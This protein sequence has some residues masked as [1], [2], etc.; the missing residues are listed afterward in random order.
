MMK[1]S[2]N[3][4][5]IATLSMLIIFM[6]FIVFVNLSVKLD[7]LDEIDIIMPDLTQV[8]DGTYVGSYEVFPLSVSVEVT[9]TSQVI[10]MI[11]ITE[12]SLF[13]D[14]QAEDIISFILQSQTLD[15]AFSEDY[16]QSEKI[17]LLAITNALEVLEFAE[18]DEA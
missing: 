12:S 18:V 10:T 6:L 14:Q 4:A 11:L 5:I 2:P 9:V 17:L 3:I 16:E 8:P 15:I 7:A 1:K 13:F